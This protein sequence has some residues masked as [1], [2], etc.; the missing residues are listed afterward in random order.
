MNW[1]A[2]GAIGE[3]TG[4]LA[5]VVTLLYLAAQIKHA[6]ADSRKALSQARVEGIR[7]LFALATDER[8]NRVAVKT[9]EALGTRQPPFVSA[10]IEQVGLTKEE[11]SLL[12]N[13]HLS[14]WNTVVQIIPNVD[15]LPETE[16][17]V[18]DLGILGRYSQNS[19]GGL[20]FETVKAGAH[21]DVV[22]YIEGVLE[23]PV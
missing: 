3:L 17:R 16:R 21:P 7:E 13:F 11:A 10:L 14:W 6:R 18:F 12:F 20:F 9:S 1:S 23:Q 22:A 5:V 4:A 19:A 2:I 15:E 8:I